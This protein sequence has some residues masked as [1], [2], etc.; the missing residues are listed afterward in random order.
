MKITSLQKETKT[1]ELKRKAK[2]YFQFIIPI[3][4]IIG[5]IFFA[6]QTLIK[7]DVDFLSSFYVLE[8]KEI[9]FS[10]KEIIENSKFNYNF[11]EKLKVEWENK[12]YSKLNWLK[13]PVDRNELLWFNSKE[14]FKLKREVSYKWLYIDD[15]NSVVWKLISKK[16]KVF[17]TGLSQN[18]S[19][20]SYEKLYK[21][22]KKWEFSNLVDKANSDISDWY[23]IEYKDLYDL[24]GLKEKLWD[25]KI[26]LM[27]L[28]KNDI[29]NIYFNWEEYKYFNWIVLFIEDDEDLTKIKNRLL[30]L[31]KILS[32]QN[33]TWKKI[34]LLTNNNKEVY[35]FLWDK[36]VESAIL[37]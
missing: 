19:K 3:I 25:K 30:T 37:W 11:D 28:T 6:Y 31:I 2:L 20:N 36:R 17:L 14:L 15:F 4:T 22:V 8:E 24:K 9:T 35:K 7:S 1:E 13:Q 10:D 32:V 12:L 16:Y 21:I 33:D 27:W 18:P 34:I 29:K 23:F 26:Y 5:I